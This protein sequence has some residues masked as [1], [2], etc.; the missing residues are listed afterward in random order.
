MFYQ[1]YS[2]HFSVSGIAPACINALFPNKTEKNYNRFLQALI[3]LAPNC[4]PEKVLLEIRA[5]CFLVLPKTF[6]EASLL[7]CFFHLSQSYTRTINELGLNLTYK[8]NHGLML[9]LRMLPSLA[10]EKKKIGDRNCLEP[11]KIDEM[12]L[13]FGSTYIKSLVPNREVLFPTSLWNQ[14]EAAM[15]GIART[16]NAVEGWHFGIQSYFSGA[17]PNLWKVIDSLQKDAS[18]QILNSFDAWSGHK[19]TK[20]KKYRVLNERVQNIMSVYE[21]KTDL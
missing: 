7:G 3:D 16:T 1:L 20:K 13:Y 15:S 9:A 5:S 6:L 2:I 17:H 12:C 4:R 11:E 18:V 14:R 8:T 10:F 19:F 21:D